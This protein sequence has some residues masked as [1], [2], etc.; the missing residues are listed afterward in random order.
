M[1][2]L[3]VFMLLLTSPVLAAPTTMTAEQDH[4]AMMDQ[5]GIASLRQ[6]AN[7]NNRQAPNAAN[8]DES[9]VNPFTLPDPLA[10]KNGQKVMAADEWWKKR[11]PEI[12]ED[13]DREIY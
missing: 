12:V 2:I 1:P 9:K 8:Y 11:R 6:G 7:G 4:Q 10:M 13:F 5:L 3:A